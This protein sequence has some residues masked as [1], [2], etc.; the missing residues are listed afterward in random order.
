EVFLSDL[1]LK[2]KKSQ[3]SNN[4]NSLGT[5][6]IATSFI[7]FFLEWID[8]GELIGLGLPNGTFEPFHL[9]LMKGCILFESILKLRKPNTKGKQTIDTYISSHHKELGFG[10]D[11]FR[12]SGRSFP[13]VVKNWEN[14]N[15]R[16]ITEAIEVSA[17][18]RNTISHTF[19][20]DV[21]ITPIGYQSIASAISSA[22]FQA[23]LLKQK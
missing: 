23:I 4:T 16:T 6:T 5:Q 1:L 10:A 15:A 2:K 8:R 7:T 20:S 9:H 18:I 11:N 14:K 22:C 3:D 12:L 19:D 13:E 21:K 17:Q